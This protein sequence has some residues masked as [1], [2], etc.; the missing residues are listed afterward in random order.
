MLNLPPEDETFPHPASVFTRDC[1]ASKIKQTYV[2]YRK[3]VDTGHQNGGSIVV[4]TFFIS[5][6]K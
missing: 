3:A 1:I 4:A 2:K 6:T 5:V